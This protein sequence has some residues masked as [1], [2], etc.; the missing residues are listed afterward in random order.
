MFYLICSVLEFKMSSNSVELDSARKWHRG[1]G[2]LNHADVVR[3]SLETVV[4]LDDVC[5]VCEL[6]KIT[7][8][9]VPRVEETQAEEKLERVFTEV[10]G[11]FRVESL[12]PLSGFPFCLV[13]AD[14]YTKFVFVYLLKAK[15][16]ALASL[17]KIA[18]SVRTPKSFYRRRAYQRR[19]NRMG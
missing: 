7:K 11:P 13:F 4:Q 12:S 18:V 3:N 19:Q 1:L 15:M 17:K 16:E 2:H 6:A 5:S 8:T 14:Q 10:M 9:P